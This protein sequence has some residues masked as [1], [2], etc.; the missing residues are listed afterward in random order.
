VDKVAKTVEHG[1]DSPSQNLEPAIDLLVDLYSQHHLTKQDMTAID[2]RLHQDGYLK[3]MEITGADKQRGQLSIH[4]DQL[5]N[6]PSIQQRAE[7]QVAKEVSQGFKKSVWEGHDF[8]NV[9]PSGDGE[10]DGKGR[11]SVGVNYES[12]AGT[13]GAARVPDYIDSHKSQPIKPVQ[14]F[15]F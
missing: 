3:N 5:P 9:H 4:F 8:Q 11:L 13:S 2:N 14:S 12:L 7:Q 10:I 1:I 15:R 6:D